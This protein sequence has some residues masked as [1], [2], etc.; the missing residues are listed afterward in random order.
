M[1]H[2]GHPHP[3]QLTG[4]SM[5][6]PQTTGFPGPTRVVIVGTTATPPTIYM[7]L[8]IGL[9]AGLVLGWVIAQ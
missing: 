4:L 3:F 8:L 1:Q 6:T 2:F 5:G 7:P 9:G